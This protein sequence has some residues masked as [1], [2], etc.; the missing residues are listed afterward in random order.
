MPELF[1]ILPWETLIYAQWVATWENKLFDPKWVRKHGTKGL[2]L[3]F[4]NGS[5]YKMAKRKAQNVSTGQSTITWCNVAL[6]DD[7]ELS[8]EH[9]D[10]SDAELFAA[11]ITLVDSGHAIFHKAASDGDG[12]TFGATGQS[13]DCVNRGLGLSAYADNP[14]DAVKVFVYKH[15]G[16]LAGKW[17]APASGQKR[18]FR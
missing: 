3:V 17:P 8:L 10:V 18:R 9:W 12:F 14:R 1:H 11:V 15:H 13:D 4:I 6:P 16:L 7:V 2:S 5:E